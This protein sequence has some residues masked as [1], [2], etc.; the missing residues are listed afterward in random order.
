LVL[1]LEYRNRSPG[2]AASGMLAWAA[3]VSA[4]PNSMRSAAL[5]GSA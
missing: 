3:P 1:P 2:F 5:F 4:L